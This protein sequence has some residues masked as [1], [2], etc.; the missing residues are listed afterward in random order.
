MNMYRIKRFARVSTENMNYDK[1]IWGLDED[2]PMYAQPEGSMSYPD[3]KSRDKGYS[4]YNIVWEN[5][6]IM[7][8]KFILDPLTPRVKNQMKRI[9]SISLDR[10]NICLDH[11]RNGRFVYT[12]DDKTQDDNSIYY[13]D[14]PIYYKWDT[15]T[16]YL[17]DMQDESEDE[18]PY[19]K[20]LNKN[21]RL[22]YAVKRPVRERGEWVCHIRI[23]S[24][25]GHLFNQRRYSEYS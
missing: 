21:N 4:G 20:H 13:G 7:I 14:N 8:D 10:M 1:H 3:N 19:S 2:D 5:N 9:D 23:S 24:C 18:L 17:A 16:H 15:Q 12:D 6:G 25:E 11:L 22:T